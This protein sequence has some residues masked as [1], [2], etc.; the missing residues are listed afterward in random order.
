MTRQKRHGRRT[1]KDRLVGFVKAIRRVF[2]PGRHATGDRSLARQKAPFQP[3][4]R[5]WTRSPWCDACDQPVDALHPKCG[6]CP[7]CCP[8]EPEDDD[9]QG[10]T[11]NGKF[12][13][14][15]EDQ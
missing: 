11:D 7:G 14:S 13:F 9:D 5:P 4:R 10:P 12:R 8:C 6:Y 3:G 2:A 1:P 15:V